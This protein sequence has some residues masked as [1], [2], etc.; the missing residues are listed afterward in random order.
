MAKSSK[1]LA[2]QRAQFE[3]TIAGAKKYAAQLPKEIQPVIKGLEADAAE[4]GAINTKQEAAKAQLAALT[5][6]LRAKVKAATA[7]R[8]KVMRQAEA[9][10]GIGAPEMKDFRSATDGKL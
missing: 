8:T 7:K 9:T 1:S 4:I 2:N 3:L 5:G 10:F 6:E